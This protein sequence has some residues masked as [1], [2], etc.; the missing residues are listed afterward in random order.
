MGCSTA[1]F[2]KARARRRYL[3]HR[4]GS[5][6]R[7]RLDV[8]RVGWCARVVLL[9]RNHQDVEVEHRIHSALRS[10]DGRWRAASAGRLGRRRISVHRA[11]GR[12]VDA[13]GQL[14]DAAPAWL[15]R[16]I[17]E[18]RGTKGAFPIDAYR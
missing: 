17:A 1:Y 6:L 5:D 3:R 13:R 8:A 16:G 2:V 9:P 12:D 14:R 18:S 15:R 7:T 4:A 10:D 11:A